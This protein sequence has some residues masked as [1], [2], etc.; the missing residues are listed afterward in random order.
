MKGKHI[1]KVRDFNRFYTNQLGLLDQY[2][3]HSRYSLAE[4]RV[5]FELYHHNNLTAKAITGM[6]QM[7]KGFLSRLLRMFEKNGLIKRLSSKEDG[8]VV[9]ISLTPAGRKEYEVL[10]KEANEQIDS[11]LKSI[12]RQD[13]ERLIDSMTTIKKILSR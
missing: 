1:D 3:Y 6:V 9:Q 2:I 12:S 8:R 4:V 13:R 5:L 10:D 11:I 7:D